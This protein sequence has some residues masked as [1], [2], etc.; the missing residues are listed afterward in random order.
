M[1][2]SENWVHLARTSI[3]LWKSP[4]V[5]H[6]ARDAAEIVLSLTTPCNDSI[7]AP[8]IP[9]RFSITPPIIVQYRR[10]RR[11]S[12]SSN[13]S[14]AAP[15]SSILTTFRQRLPDNDSPTLPFRTLQQLPYHTI[16]HSS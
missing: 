5:S 13:D 11:A 10:R 15:L 3:F 14:L 2:F 7:T 6:S 9:R 16:L 12:W 4:K 8:F 1:T